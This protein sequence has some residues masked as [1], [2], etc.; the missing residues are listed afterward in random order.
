MQALNI[1]NEINDNYGIA[2]SYLNI[3]I[4]YAKQGEFNKAI[5]NNIKALKIYE[6]SQYYQ[7]LAFCLNQLGSSFRELGDSE[8]ALNY[9]RKSLKYYEE[10]GN[11]N[12][13]AKAYIE[14][15][16]IYLF[17]SISDS[18]DYYFNILRKGFRNN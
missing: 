11:T 13:Q 14:I 12:E 18:A 17:K 7:G 5:E 6:K 15:G 4:S 2:S 9:L 10:L 16:S 8:R 1:R 3:G